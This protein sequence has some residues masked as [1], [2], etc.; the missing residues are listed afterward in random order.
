MWFLKTGCHEPQRNVI[1]ALFW[2]LLS[3]FLA[4]KPSEY[5]TVI[6]P[7][8]KVH[9]VFEAWAELAHLHFYFILSAKTSH[10]VNSYS[11]GGKID[12]SLDGKSYKYKSQKVWIWGRV[13]NQ[14]YVCNHSNPFIIYPLP[15]NLHVANKCLHPH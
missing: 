4:H 3:F 6:L 5:C 7:L 1:M 14:G 2:C 11:R 13:E 10:K 15:K 8:V 12:F 9:K